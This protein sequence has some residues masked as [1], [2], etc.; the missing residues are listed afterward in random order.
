MFTK[1]A[2]YLQGLLEVHALLRLAIR[3]NR[4]SLVGNLFAGRLTIADAFR[5]DPVFE[6]GWLVPATYVPAWASDLI[7]LQ[8]RRCERHR[9]RRGRRHSVDRAVV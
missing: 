1:D 3:D 9:G 4:P 8:D 6:S 5:L 7:A 2:V